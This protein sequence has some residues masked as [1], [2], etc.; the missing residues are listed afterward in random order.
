MCIE[1]RSWWQ[2][3]GGPIRGRQMLNSG[4]LQ[5]G[6]VASICPDKGHAHSCASYHNKKIQTGVLRRGSGGFFVNRSVI[7]DIVKVIAIDG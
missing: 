2:M 3:C 4:R 1:T 6:Q 5:L 7:V